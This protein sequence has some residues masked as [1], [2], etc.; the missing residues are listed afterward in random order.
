MFVARHPVKG[1][2]NLVGFYH[3]QD[4]VF[5]DPTKKNGTVITDAAGEAWKNVGVAYSSD[6]G[7]TWKDGGIVLSSFVPKPETPTWGGLG[8]FGAIWDWK[9]SHWKVYFKEQQRLGVAVST[10][11]DAKPGSFYKWRWLGASGSQPDVSEWPAGTK[12]PPGPEW[13]SPGLGGVYTGLPGLN[14]IPGA[15]PGLHWNTYLQVGSKR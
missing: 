1:G 5:G 15:N 13:E 2:S 7:V 9:A 14:D 4:H 10:D 6:D 8:D 11:P 12:E 3:S